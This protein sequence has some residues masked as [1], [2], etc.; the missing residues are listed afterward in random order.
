VIRLLARMGLLL[1]VLGF[2]GGAGGL[3]VGADWSQKLSP[4]LRAAL[5]V[6]P[7]GRQITVIVTLADQVALPDLSGMERAA[8]LERVVRS[9]KARAEAAQRPLR[10]AIATWQGQGR[11]SRATYFWIF[12]GLALTATA[13]VVQE[14][15]AR[16]DVRSII[17]E[18]IIPGPPPPGAAAP[19]AASTTPP[20][21]TLIHAPELWLLGFKGQGVVVGSL[22]TGVTLNHP[23]LA[24]RWRG[25]SNSWFDPYASAPL[26]TDSNGHGTET[27]GVILGR[28]ASGTSIGV[29]PQAQWIA[30]RIFS[31][32]SNS[33]SDTA[34][35]QAFQ[36]LL[37]PDGNPATPDA[38]QVV[39][40]SWGVTTPGCDTR[41]QADVQALR[42]A[43]ILPVFAAGNYG[44][45][46]GTGVSPANYPESLAV[47]A[48]DN[49]SNIFNLSSRGPSAC[50][51]SMTVFPQ[52]VAPGVGIYTSAPTGYTTVSGTSLAAP[53][54][55]GA[56]ALL[57]SAHPNLTVD[58][59]Q[60]ALL[61]TALDLGVPGPDESYGFGRLD[62]L[63]AS[64]LP[65]PRPS[66]L[67][68][69]LNQPTPVP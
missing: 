10:E 15:A 40:N 36:W 16:P 38:P 19:A 9:L 35:H 52:L 29:A 13:G 53:H 23:D 69:V 59:Q 66:Y 3:A 50:P 47:G 30:A 28:D 49:T 33:T 60:T 34:V 48:I 22:D 57:L 31:P 55:A 41:F 65:A 26:P 27:M 12:D 21:L 63:A 6:L 25:G 54:V 20:N 18:V 11:V 42:S 2:S 43:G 68:A 17:P 56:L 39:N 5:A 61:S 46:L 45:G 67:P 24:A 8:R 62:A 37:D 14:L 7:E 1:V 64:G 51:G 4:P 58:Q 44:P 32:I